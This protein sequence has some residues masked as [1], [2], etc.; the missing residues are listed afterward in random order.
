MSLSSNPL[1][2]WLRNNVSIGAPNLAN[3]VNPDFWHDLAVT[4][5]KLGGMQLPQPTNSAWLGDTGGYM[6]SLGGDASPPAGPTTANPAPRRPVT[7][8]PATAYPQAMPSRPVTSTPATAY[9]SHIPIGGGAGN[10]MEAPTG[11]PS[12]TP[13]PASSDRFIQIDRVN[14]GPLAQPGRGYQTALNLANLFRRG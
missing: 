6:P 4:K 8:T 14:A 10:V 2:N 12:Q 1:T 9:P 11:S 3:A 7:P 5:Q 13:R